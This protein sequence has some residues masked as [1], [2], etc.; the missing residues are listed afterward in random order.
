MVEMLSSAAEVKQLEEEA[1]I[2]QKFEKTTKS[3]ERL[4]LGD[5]A[6]FRFLKGN[7]DEKIASKD[8]FINV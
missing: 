2:V 8:H 7:F 5:Q 1:K 4:M 3:R 6:Y